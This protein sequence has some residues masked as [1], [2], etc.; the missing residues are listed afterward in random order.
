MNNETRRRSLRGGGEKQPAAD[1]YDFDAY[2]RTGVSEQL[3]M[4]VVS[5][6]PVGARLRHN[7]ELDDFRGRIEQYPVNLVDLRASKGRRK[8]AK[9]HV[10]PGKRKKDPLESKF[11]EAFHSRGEKEEKRFAREDRNKLVR[12]YQN[13]KEALKKFGETRGAPRGDRLKYLTEVTKINNIQDP[14]EV[15]IK[16]MLTI[17]ELIHFAMNYDKFKRREAD[18]KATLEAD[19][20]DEPDGDITEIRARRK[21][22]MIRNHG[23]V[24]RVKFLNGVTLELDPMGRAKIRKL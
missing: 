16:F 19:R 2:L 9:V 13:C 4:E 10:E 23:P 20:W 7:P 21:R 11:F 3:T 18:L 22:R 17:K 6:V 5:E 24:I 14:V 12:E 1:V 8:P 15:Q